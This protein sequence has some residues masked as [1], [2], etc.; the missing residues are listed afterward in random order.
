MKKAAIFDLD[1]TLLNTSIDLMNAVI[2]ALKSLGFIEVAVDEV[3]KKTGRGI[4]KLIEDIIDTSDIEIVQKALSLF[5]DYYFNNCTIYTYEYDGIK[6]VL[7]SLK[8]KGTKL[9]VVSNKSQELT[10]KIISFYFDDIFDFILGEREGIKRKPE[11][12]MIDLT[13]KE[14]NVKGE[15]V[16]YIGDSLI[17]LKTAENSNLD[18][19]NVSYGFVE[20]EILKLNGSKIVLDEPKEILDY[21]K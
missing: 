7:L 3:I 8:E 14:L 5:K 9:A 12:D 6:D 17:D 18:F 21:F 11:R 2:H 16:Y 20:K 1:G 10:S 19:L 4:K 13:L 15:E